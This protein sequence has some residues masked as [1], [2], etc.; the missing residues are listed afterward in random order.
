[1][2]RAKEGRAGRWIELVVE[3]GKQKK[4]T[5][6]RRTEGKKKGGIMV[7][8]EPRWKESV[9]LE[10]KGCGRQREREQEKR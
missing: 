4:A 1:M 10:S 2:G 5:N 3:G 9:V 6:S 8:G 7:R